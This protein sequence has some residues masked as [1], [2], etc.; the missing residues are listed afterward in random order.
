MLR[1]GNK[2]S[3]RYCHYQVTDRIV[4]ARVRGYSL[5]S[6]LKRKLELRDMFQKEATEICDPFG[7]ERR[8]R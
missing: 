6:F 3:G 1:D 8:K 7:W 4:K 5:G 2:I